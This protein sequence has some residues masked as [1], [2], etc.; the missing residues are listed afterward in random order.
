SLGRDPDER[1]LPEWRPKPGT[2]VLDMVYQPHRTRLLADVEA[3]GGI[4]VAGLEMFLTQATAQL[5]L[6]AGATLAETELRAFLAGAV[7]GGPWRPAHEL[8]AVGRPRRG[9]GRTARGGQEHRGPAA[10]RAPRLPVRRRRRS[11]GGGGGPAGRRI[12]GRGRRAGVPAARG[13]GHR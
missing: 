13:A 5:E 6:F 2:V 4:P 9:A 11:A 12:P 1:L 3:A 7:T 10:G 8:A